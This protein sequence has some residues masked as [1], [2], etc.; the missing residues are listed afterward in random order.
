MSRAKTIF[1]VYPRYTPGSPAQ[2]DEVTAQRVAK[3][4]ES[5]FNRIK[6]GR[7][8]LDMDTSLGLSGIALSWQEIGKGVVVRDLITGET[9][10]FATTTA[11]QQYTNGLRKP[12]F[13]TVSHA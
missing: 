2:V 9:L 8:G 3:Q 5:N 6:D 11:F 10:T 13:K 12:E 7:Y 4:E 1:G